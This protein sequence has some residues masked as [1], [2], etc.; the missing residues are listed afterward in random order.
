MDL[1]A[2]R[3]EYNIAVRARQ[4]DEVFWNWGRGNGTAT[5]AARAA[6]EVDAFCPSAKDV[7]A[8]LSVKKMIENDW[9]PINN[10]RK[11]RIK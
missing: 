6:N 8:M 4:N 1:S 7:C 10:N 11:E 2:H 3:S 5:P 9:D